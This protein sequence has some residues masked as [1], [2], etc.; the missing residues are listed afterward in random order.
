MALQYTSVDR[1]LIFDPKIS[2][3]SSVTTAAMGLF[4]AD[5]EAVVNGYIVRHYTLPLTFPTSGGTAPLLVAIATDLALWRVYRRLFTQQQL[6]DSAWPAQFK[7]AMDLLEDIADG[8]ILLQ[9]SD[10]T[11]IGGRTDTSPIWSNT[12]GYV[13]TFSELDPEFSYTS[14]DKITDLG[15]D[16]NE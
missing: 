2:S 14:T 4:A 5:A 9:D 8:E 1:M 11:V 13:P 10:G 6:K 3:A 16:R 12:M 7:S 15:G